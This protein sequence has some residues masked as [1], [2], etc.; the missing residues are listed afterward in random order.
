MERYDR[1]VKIL[2]T[3]L[4]CFLSAFLLFS[5]FS[6]GEAVEWTSYVSAESEEQVILVNI[7]TA[8]AEELEENLEGIGPVLAKRIVDYRR[9]NGPFCS[10][11][12]LLNVKGIGEQ[13]LEKIRGQI[14]L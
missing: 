7:N 11:E 3:L 12:D 2:S 14:Q 8:S 5:A 10:P 9:L 13:K 4:L 6:G 1:Q